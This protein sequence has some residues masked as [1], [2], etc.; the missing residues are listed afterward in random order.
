MGR[1]NEFAAPPAPAHRARPDMRPIVDE[2]ARDAAYPVHIPGERS[3][4]RFAPDYCSPLFPCR[5]VPYA[6]LKRAF[7]I[8]ICAVALV[9]LSPLFA[10][11]AIV[12]RITSRGPAIFKQVRVGA[13]GRYFWCYKFRSMVVDAEQKLGH[14]AHLNEA[15]GPVFKIK[16][17]P[18]VTQVG[19]FLRRASLDELPQLWNV[20]RGDM[21]IVG[22]R[23][24]LPSEVELYSAR[25]RGRLAVRPGLTCLWQCRGR[26]NVPFDEW[27]QMDLD[28][29]ATMSF[30]RDIRIV[31]DTIPA[32]LLGVG[33]H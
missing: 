32:V 10:T 17:D 12:V 19:G 3:T 11:I 7:D 15:T 23:P 24:P 2:V 13:G 31:L 26:S 33:A 8:A 9:L 27:V 22:P 1:I 30:R 6:R 25:E 5:D 14:V 20:L 18:R 4:D 29:I 21:S 28:Y 16:N